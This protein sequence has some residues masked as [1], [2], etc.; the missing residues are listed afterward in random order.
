MRSKT[1]FQKGHIGYKYW[2]G[3]K[4]PTIGEKVR[5]K[6]KGRKLSEETKRKM[7]IARK[8]KPQLW[9][10]GKP[11]WNKNKVCPQLRG[12]NHW[13][14]QGGISNI[15][16]NIRKSTEYKLWR[17]A[18]LER[19]NFTCIWCYSKEELGVDHIKPFALY[20]ELRFAIDNGRTLCNECHLTT[21]TYGG[22]S[23]K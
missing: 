3:K 20:P 5:N 2:L 22:N 17:Q 10:K 15:N 6:L 18:V 23:K 13:N 8:G 19:D 16:E 12:I 21:E 11:S 4:R 14:W 7:S 9:H 1:T